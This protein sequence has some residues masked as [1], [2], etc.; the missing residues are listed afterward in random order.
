MEEWKEID[1]EMNMDV[2]V[3]VD[4]A[5]HEKNNSRQNKLVLMDINFDTEGKLQKKID[6]YENSS[7]KQKKPHGSK[8]AADTPKC[9]G[10]PH[11]YIMEEVRS[12]YYSRNGPLM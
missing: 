6:N 10:L 8:V 5:N 7:N 4:V 1:R 11:K 2:G 12:K 9:S 3:G